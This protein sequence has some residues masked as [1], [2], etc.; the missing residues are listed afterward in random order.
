M[1]G[2]PL[3]GRAVSVILQAIRDGV[4]QSELGDALEVGYRAFGEVAAGPAA[5]EGIGAFL[6]KRKP[7]FT[8]M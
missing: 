7:D 8:G 5:K 3:S 4:K 6:Q 2:T 1:D